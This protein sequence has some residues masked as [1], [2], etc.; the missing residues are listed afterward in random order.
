MIVKKDTLINRYK[1]D[2]NQ[3]ELETFKSILIGSY[4]SNGVTWNKIKRLKGK[5]KL[6]CLINIK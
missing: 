2:K 6:K 1:I 5:D 4:F 3:L